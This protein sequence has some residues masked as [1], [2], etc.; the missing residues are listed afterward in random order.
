MPEIKSE[1]VNLRD[2]QKV[3]V[4]SSQE[5]MTA[6]ACLGEL[7]DQGVEYTLLEYS[8]SIARLQ[9]SSRNLKKAA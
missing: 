4:N 7:Q 3:L 9:A 2:L 5:L 8:A 1:L 6:I